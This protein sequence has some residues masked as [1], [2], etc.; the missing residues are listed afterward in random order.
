MKNTVHLYRSMRPP[1]TRF[2]TPSASTPA[3]SYYDTCGI[4][5]C[6][7]RG[8]ARKGGCSS[9]DEVVGRA[10]VVVAATAALTHFFGLVHVR[11]FCTVRPL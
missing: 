4:P 7:Q 1:T 5:S 10:A 6:L 2:T 11:A 3:F 9:L 8:R